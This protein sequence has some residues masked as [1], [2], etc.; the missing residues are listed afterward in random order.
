MAQVLFQAQLQLSNCLSHTKI[1]SRACQ[2]KEKISKYPCITHTLCK[3][4][5][6]GETGR[7]LASLIIIN[8]LVMKIFMIMYQNT[9]NYKN[10]FRFVWLKRFLH[11]EVFKWQI[12]ASRFLNH[13]WFLHAGFYC[14]IFDQISLQYFYMLSSTCG[15]LLY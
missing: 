1:S 12:S 9:H 15:C 6:V 2:L 13:Y 10:L 4:I 11:F 7:R 3:K 14:I 8:S 5:Y